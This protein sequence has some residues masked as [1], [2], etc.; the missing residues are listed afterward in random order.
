MILSGPENVFI[1]H[2]VAISSPNLRIPPSSLFPSKNPSF[3]QFRKSCTIPLQ[4]S[5]TQT[6][7]SLSISV[8]NKAFVLT[9]K[10]M[11]Q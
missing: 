4:T 1:S 5:F 8:E 7:I 11:Q 3:Y 9:C 2:G 6:E 10:I